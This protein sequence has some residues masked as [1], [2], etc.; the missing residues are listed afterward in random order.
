MQAGKSCSAEERN[1]IEAKSSLDF[2]C[3]VTCK[4][5]YADVEWDEEVEK[6]NKEKI[7]RLT[8]EYKKFKKRN[9]QHFRFNSSSIDA[10]GKGS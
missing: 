4:G 1:C 2:N 10:S 9:I 6:E 8:T 7:L 5:V 3:S